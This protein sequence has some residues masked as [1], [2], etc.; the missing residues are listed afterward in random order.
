MSA[1]KRLFLLLLICLVMTVFFSISVASGAGP[2]LVVNP[3]KTVLSPALLKK[4]IMIT[5]SGWKPGE[6]VVVNMILPQGVTVKGVNPG[7]P[8]GIANGTADAQGA[9]KTKVGETEWFEVHPGF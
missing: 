6:I 4:P 7:D 5:G 2:A 9:F 8:V 1:H 3:D